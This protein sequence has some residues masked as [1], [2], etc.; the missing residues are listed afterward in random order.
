MIASN[1]V[2]NFDCGILRIRDV[3]VVPVVNRLLLRSGVHGNIVPRP[4]RAT[5]I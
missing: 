5:P 1:H 2:H 3:V 4:R